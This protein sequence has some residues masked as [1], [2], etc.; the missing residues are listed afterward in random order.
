MGAIACRAAECAQARASSRRRIRPMTAAE[1]P[2]TGRLALD[3]LDATGASKDDA[4]APEPADSTL[5]CDADNDAD[6]FSCAT[7]CTRPNSRP[8]TSSGPLDGVPGLARRLRMR[9]ESGDRPHF[10]DRH[11]EHGG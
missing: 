5:H 2:W 9:G 6:A 4:G 8:A 7:N 11:D 3:P 10:A 1:R